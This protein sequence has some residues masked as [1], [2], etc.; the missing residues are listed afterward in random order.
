[1][2]LGW[3]THNLRS[4]ISPSTKVGKS[5]SEKIEQFNKRKVN[6]KDIPMRAL[7]YIIDRGE[8]N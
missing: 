6:K 1:M 7:P 2:A 3:I 5:P 4:V 8:E